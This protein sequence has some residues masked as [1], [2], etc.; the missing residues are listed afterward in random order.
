MKGGEM[1]PWAHPQSSGWMTP[2]PVR[3]PL[4]LRSKKPL[5]RCCHVP[6]SP[7]YPSPPGAWGRTQCP[8]VLVCRDPSRPLL[9]PRCLETRGWGGGCSAWWPCSDAQK[10]ASSETATPKDPKRHRLFVAAAGT[11]PPREHTDDSH[12]SAGWGLGGEEGNTAMAS[13]VPRV[14]ILTHTPLRP[15][16]QGPGR[17]CPC[18]RLPCC[19]EAQAPPWHAARGARC[20]GPPILGS[21]T[22]EIP[23][24]GFVRKAQRETPTRDCLARRRPPARHGSPGVCHAG[25]EVSLRLPSPCSPWGSGWH[26][27]HTAQAVQVRGALEFAAAKV[28]VEVGRWDRLR[29]SL[30]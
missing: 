1:S 29:S 24:P 7:A 26:L 12:S 27:L 18:F 22:T 25:V 19:L 14:L 20:R 6:R 30:L 28:T 10:A 17:V 11:A 8:P 15:T 9:A 13:A 5:T 2:G 21:A 4:A 16:N 3:P 23:K